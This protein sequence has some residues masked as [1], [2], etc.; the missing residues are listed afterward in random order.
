ME[1]KRKEEKEIPIKI[2]KLLF[3]YGLENLKIE[4]IKNMHCNKIGE[5]IH[6]L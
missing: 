1:E 5:D 2:V 6:E 3:K 4:E